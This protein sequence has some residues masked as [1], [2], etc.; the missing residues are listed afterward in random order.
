MKIL[1]G[2]R[3]LGDALRRVPGSKAG[4]CCGRCGADV[5]LAPSGQRVAAGGAPV[6]CTE[7]WLAVAGAGDRVGLARGAMCELAAYRR[8][9]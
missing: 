1:V 9:N 6:I 3:N 2:A 8:R 4:Y 7:C 5:V